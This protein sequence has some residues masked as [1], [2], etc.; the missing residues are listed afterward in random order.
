[1]QIIKLLRRDIDLRSIV[2]EFGK[3]I[4]EEIDYLQEARNAQVLVAA[5]T[6]VWGLKLLV[7][8]VLVYAASW[9]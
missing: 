4:Y 7:Y 2:E 3:L 6:S 9:Y 5:I 1:M 8:E